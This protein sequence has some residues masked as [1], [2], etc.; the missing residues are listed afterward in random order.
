MICTI[1]GCSGKHIAKGMCKQ[2]YYRKYS[3]E[4]RDPINERRFA[5]RRRYRDEWPKEWEDRASFADDIGQPPSVGYRLRKIDPS[6][7]ISKENVCWAPPLPITVKAADDMAEYHRQSRR[8]REYKMLPSEYTTMVEQQGGLCLI[9]GLPPSRMA[10][11]KR[12]HGLVVDHD[13]V[14]GAVRGLICQPCN[15]GLGAFKDSAK[16]L[17]AAAGYLARK[18]LN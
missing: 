7:P 2:H 10:K 17:I 6:K 12:K 4:N 9:C 1:D 13:H 11:G 3:K 5:F 14:T 8:L 16:N 18:R 15:V